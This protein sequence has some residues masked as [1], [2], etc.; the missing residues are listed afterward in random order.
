M[1]CDVC[2]TCDM[3]PT[4]EEFI[5]QMD[6]IAC[7]SDAQKS[8]G[9][10]KTILASGA[11]KYKAAAGVVQELVVLVKAKRKAVNKGATA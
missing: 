5:K 8:V 11:E 1:A 7:K 4:P 2:I 6:K 9:E 3:Q 10:I